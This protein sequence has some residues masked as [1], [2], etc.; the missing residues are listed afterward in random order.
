MVRIVKIDG[1]AM[2]DTDRSGGLEWCPSCGSGNMRR[3]IAGGETK[4][5]CRECGCCWFFAAGQFRS[6]DPRARAGC[7]SRPV[8]VRRL[9]ERPDW[10]YGDDGRCD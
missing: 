7:S 9:W 5:L 6:T 10:T 1:P 4:H 3:V 8:C 2:D